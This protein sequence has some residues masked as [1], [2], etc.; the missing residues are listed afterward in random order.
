MKYKFKNLLF[1]AIILIICII[2]VIGYIYNNSKDWKKVSNICYNYKRE[3]VSADTLDKCLSIAKDKKYTHI[4]F[5]KDGCTTCSQSGY[6]CYLSNI[7]SHCEWG[8]SKTSDN[9][10]SFNYNQ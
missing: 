10:V 2:F 8:P 5:Y 3:A 1:P 4:D 7:D 9:V 6:K